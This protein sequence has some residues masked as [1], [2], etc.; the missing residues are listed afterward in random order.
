[1]LS[2]SRQEDLRIRGGPRRIVRCASSHLLRLFPSAALPFPP[3]RLFF[4]YSGGSRGIAEGKGRSRRGRGRARGHHCARGRRPTRP[5]RP[6]GPARLAADANGPAGGAARRLGKATGAHLPTSAPQPSSSSRSSTNPDEKGSILRPGTSVSPSHRNRWLRGQDDRRDGAGRMG[7][8]WTWRAQEPHT[9]LR[10]GLF[11]AITPIL[12]SP[13]AFLVRKAHYLHFTP[14]MFPSPSSAPSA[15]GRPSTAKGHDAAPLD[16]GRPSGRPRPGSARARRPLRW[17]GRGTKRGIGAPYGRPPPAMGGPGPADPN[18][19]PPLAAG[20]ETAPRGD[21]GGRPGRRPVH[22]RSTAIG[23]GRG[24]TRGASPA[25]RP[26]RYGRRS[27]LRQDARCAPVE[28]RSPVTNSTSG[29]RL[30]APSHD[31]RRTTPSG[32]RARPQGHGRGRPPGSAPSRPRRPQ[33]AAH[34]ASQRPYPLS[35]PVV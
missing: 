34:A 12:T 27:A 5:F 23:P 21:L 3:L 15:Y 14:T 8:G 25:A 22:A 13:G 10:P 32:E 9:S 35:R 26:S 1:M 11:R 24:G 31:D 29:G 33:D 6:I 20:A 17:A 2:P 16:G 4:S 19:L 30:P 28:D 18:D 7:A